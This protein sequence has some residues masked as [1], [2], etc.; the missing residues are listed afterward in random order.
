MFLQ[1]KK[2]K[3]KKVKKGVIKKIN[4]K[5]NKLRLGDIGLKASE[6]GLITSK[7]LEAARQAVSRKTARMGK[8]LIRIFPDLPISRKPSDSRMGKGK[9]ANSH[10]SAKVKCGTVIFELL[11]VKKSTAIEAFKTGGAKLPIK[12]KIFE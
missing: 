7:Q 1:P 9:G 6:S 10:W 4:F 2:L 11:G 8:L 3:Y 5:A 12:T